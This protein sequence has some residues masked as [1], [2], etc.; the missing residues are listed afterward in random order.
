MIEK[1]Q[2]VKIENKIT[3]SGSN[4]IN[5][6]SNPK[7][8]WDRIFDREQYIETTNTVLGTIVHYCANQY[9]TTRQVSS[10]E[11]E[12]YLQ[13]V[14]SSVDRDFIRNCYKD[15]GNKLFEWLDSRVF[16]SFKSEIPLKAEIS[17]YG[18]L[19]GTCDLIMG[20]TLVDF[21]T[22]SQFTEHTDIARHY[23]QQL[24]AYYYLCHKNDIV[25]NQAKIVYISVPRIGEN[26]P[27]TGKPLKDYPCKVYE[28]PLANEYL[29]ILK[30][31]KYLKAIGEQIDFIKENPDKA[32]LITREGVE[33]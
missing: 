3:F 6:Y 7:R 16:G 2:I 8:F 22:T 11:I 27:K 14:D 12:N 30:I 32:H 19:T 17:K 21:K 25:I 10:Q 18:V 9:L 5:F 29:D 23:V 13:R 28:I 26:S 1:Y 33:L 24:Q 4:L 15:M 20:D 31:D